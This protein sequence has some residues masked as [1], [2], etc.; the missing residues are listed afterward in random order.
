MPRHI[1]L[2]DEQLQWLRDNHEVL[3]FSELAQHMG[4]CVDTLKRILARHN[5]RHFDGAKYT[6]RFNPPT[7]NRPCM[8]CKCTKPRPRWQYICTPC[9]ERS[10]HEDYGFNL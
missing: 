10:N 9:K 3:S 2:T 7:W 8:K 4:C 1:Q 6:P 5:I